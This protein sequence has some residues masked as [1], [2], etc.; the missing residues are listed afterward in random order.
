MTDVKELHP[1]E[2]AKLEAEAAE[3]KALARK[4]KWEAKE[5][6]AKAMVA[7]IK[8]LEA[9]ESHNEDAQC[10][11]NL[12]VYRFAGPVGDASVR[13]CIQKLNLWDRT[14]PDCDIEIIFN[15][16]GGSVIDGMALFD[17]IVALSKRGGGRHKIT[18][19]TR[20]Y[21]A[22]MA[23]ILLQAGDVRWIGANSY[24][25]IHEI[26]AGTGGKL[27]EMSDDVDFY[28]RVCKQIVDIFVARGKIKR[29]DFVRNWERKDWW[30]LA[31]EA[32]R[33]GFV[34]EIR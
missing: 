17:Q 31:D 24:L 6:R 14:D 33:L 3:I 19:G 10:D 13:N 11:D 29:A 16:P 18:I 8:A 2:I 22:S 25:M 23:G 20:G 28:N 30:L 15:S 32:K 4:A 34:D 27:G 9:V 7:E 12:R 26:S 5:A 21:A 1:A